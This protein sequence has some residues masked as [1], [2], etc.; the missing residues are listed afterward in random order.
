MIDDGG[1]GGGGGGTA[2]RIDELSNT[3]DTVIQKR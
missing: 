2:G 3:T 1:G